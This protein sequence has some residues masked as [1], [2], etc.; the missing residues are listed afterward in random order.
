[1]VLH[2][3]PGHLTSLHPRNDFHFFFRIVGG[4]LLHPE[5]TR[6]RSAEKRDRGFGTVETCKNY[7]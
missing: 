5:M 6:G 3:Q 4:R 2:Y 7:P 1:M